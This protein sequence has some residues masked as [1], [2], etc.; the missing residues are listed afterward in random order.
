MSVVSELVRHLIES[1]DWKG[2]QMTPSPIKHDNA[3]LNKLI[4]GIRTT[5]DAFLTD[6]RDE[7]T[8]EMKSSIAFYR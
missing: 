3:D 5:L 2:K 7:M 1:Q 8:F 4:T 6:F